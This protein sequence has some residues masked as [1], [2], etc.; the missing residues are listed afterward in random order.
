MN[1]AT[2]TLPYLASGGGI[3]F[4][5][6]LVL[7][8]IMSF[9]RNI[10]SYFHTV[11]QPNTGNFAQCRVGLLRCNRLN[12]DTD[13]SFLR[14]PLA[15]SGFPFHRISGV[16]QCWDFAYLSQLL[17]PFTNTLINCR[18]CYTSL[19]QTIKKPPGY[20]PVYSRKILLGL[21][22]PAFIT[23]YSLYLLVDTNLVI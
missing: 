15:P 8:Q 17:P 11:G 20:M 6:F 10:R 19:F 3:L 2:V 12:L 21:S 7:L 14:R 18:H 1:L 13:T 9:P 23:L 16:M 22:Q 4:S 5:S